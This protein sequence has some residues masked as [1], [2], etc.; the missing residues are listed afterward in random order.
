MQIKTIL[1]SSLEKRLGW[2][3]A[4]EAFNTTWDNVF[5]SFKMTVN[6]L[7]GR[8]TGTWMMAS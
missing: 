4:A 6:L 1:N 5:R 7:T 8:L 3:E 2:K